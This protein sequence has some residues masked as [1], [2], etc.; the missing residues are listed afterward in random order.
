MTFLDLARYRLSNQQ[1]ARPKHQNP[2]DLVACMGGIQAQDYLGALWA[3][4]LRLPKAT[5]PEIERAA[6]DRLIVRTWPMR[7]TLHWVAAA[8]VRWMLKLLTPRVIA[9]ATT[10]FLKYEIDTDT[11]RRCEK[12]LVRSMQKGAQ[13]T[14]EEIFTVLSCAGVSVAGQ[15]GYHILW[16]LA[17]EGLICFGSRRGKQPTFV[18]LDEWVPKERNRER[19][20]MLAELAH[21]YFVS[22]GPATVQDFAWWSGLKVS[23]AK[24]V[25]EDAAPRLAQEVIGGQSY[26]V[27]R[28]ISVRSEASPTLHLLPGF[29][30]YLLGYEDRS[31]VLDAKHTSKV[32]LSNN[33]RFLPML[34]IDGRV[35]GTWVRMIKRK[36][37]TITADPFRSLKNQEAGMLVAA[38]ERYSQ[39]LGLPLEL[40][41]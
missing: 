20:E 38:A 26:W 37:V 29:D 3:I 40:S 30:E 22:H 39:F 33:G 8:D 17:Q 34:V 32:L 31:V 25:V 9:S 1:I 41:G 15:R 24:A 18:L 35:A 7:G 21:R 6:A 19:D 5:E 23:E 28:D 13:L 16:R 10:R 4:G 27:S 11:L 12:A 36:S 2:S 14:R